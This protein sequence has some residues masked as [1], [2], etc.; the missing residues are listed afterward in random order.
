MNEE[1]KQQFKQ[2]VVQ[3]VLDTLGRYSDIPLDVE[4]A[5]SRRLN[6]RT[7]PTISTGSKGATS[8]N[9]AVDESGSGTYTVLKTPDS[10]KLLTDANGANIGYV[11]VWTS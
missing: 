5:F 11:A 2:E 3:E 7:V 6:L 1:Q 9:Q 10:F 4:K 8:E